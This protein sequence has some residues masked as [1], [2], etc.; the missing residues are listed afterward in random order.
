MKK[1]IVL[2]AI[3]FLLFR[4]A[5]CDVI[6]ENSHY[7]QKCAK[8]TNICDFENVSL[9]GYV[10]NLL[11]DDYCYLISSDN[12]LK[13]GYKFN[14]LEIFAVNSD[15]VEGENVDD[16]NLSNEVY[17]YKSN[18][19]IN[20][21]GGYYHDSIPIE[22]IDEFYE[23]VGFTETSVILFKWK[24]ITQYND[25]SSDFVETFVYEGDNSELMKSISSKID[26]ADVSTNFTVYPNPAAEKLKV[27]IE[28]DIIGT[29]ELAIYTA[30]GKK[31]STYTVFK[32]EEM[33]DYEILIDVLNKGI[34]IVG[35]KFDDIVETERFIIE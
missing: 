25:G 5:F 15:C 27:S 28:N 17:A 21:H 11:G 35:F 22:R 4:I 26:I 8:I 14:T 3:F 10:Q 23:I 2:T 31:V 7:V 24:Q 18:I 34:Y 33:I 32:N 1:N 20:P 12:C 29:I 30:Q 6:P 13:K 16:I 19:D 9:I